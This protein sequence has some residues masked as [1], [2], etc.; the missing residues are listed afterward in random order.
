MIFDTRDEDSMCAKN[1]KEKSKGEELR[2]SGKE[3]NKSQAIG[4]IRP[5]LTTHFVT[6]GTWS[7]YELLKYALKTTGPA[8]VD[9]FTWNISMPAVTQ[10]LEMK[11]GG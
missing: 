10:I 7:C 8:E 4:E 6:S 3:N 11:R 1:P 9:A 5:G 2:W